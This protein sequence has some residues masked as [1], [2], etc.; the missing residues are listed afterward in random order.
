MPRSVV[1][2]ID[3]GELRVW[4]SSDGWFHAKMAVTR[5]HGDEFYEVES[6]WDIPPNASPWAEMAG[7]ARDGERE[8][9]TDLT[10]AMFTEAVDAHAS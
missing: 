8:A 5:E 1:H 7:R 10:T 3:G 4:R 6:R 9:A 2:E